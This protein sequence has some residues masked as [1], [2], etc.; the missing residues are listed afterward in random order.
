[1][2]CTVVCMPLCRPKTLPPTKSFFLSQPETE[3]NSIIKYSRVTIVICHCFRPGLAL[4]RGLVKN[5]VWT[6][7]RPFTPSLDL[8]SGTI[9]CQTDYIGER[10]FNGIHRHTHINRTDCCIWTTRM[11]GRSIDRPTVSKSRC[12]VN[13][14]SRLKR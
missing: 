7:A 9:G 3:Q 5:R 8:T 10:S 12:L 14:V 11:V 4:I 1:M 2:F 13:I 6:R